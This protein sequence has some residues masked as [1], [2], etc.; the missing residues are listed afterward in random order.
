MV[1]KLIDVIEVLQPILL[2][3]LIQSLIIQQ[4]SNIILPIQ[5]YKFAV[6]ANLTE[7]FLIIESENQFLVVDVLAQPGS[8]VICQDFCLILPT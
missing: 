5:E 7:D 4:P 2:D 8:E 6:T 1:L 3:P